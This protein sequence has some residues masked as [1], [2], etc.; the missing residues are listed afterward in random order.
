[1]CGHMQTHTLTQDSLWEAQRLMQEEV[2]FHHSLKNCSDLC[3]VTA[4]R[5]SKH[6]RWEV[7]LK[8]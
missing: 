3:K 2:K 8:L 1:M 4:T 7:I 5:L 6:L